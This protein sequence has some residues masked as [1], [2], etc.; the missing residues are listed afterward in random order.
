MTREIQTKS[1]RWVDV[2]NA[3]PRE[4]EALKTRFGFIPLH[5]KDFAAKGQR[6]KL[7]ET[8][9]YLFLVLLFPVYD[10]KTR[11][12]VP[13]EIDF[14]LGSDYLV[15]VH[16]GK[17][18]GLT[19]LYNLVEAGGSQR[20]RLLD[21]GSVGLLLRSL[22]RLL[23][24]CCPMLDHISLDLKTVEKKIFRGE[25]RRMVSEILISRRNITDFRRI[26][27][28]HKN[29][30]KKLITALRQRG[31][32]QKPNQHFAFEALIDD[33]KEIWEQLEG[34]RETVEAL[35]GTN[36]SLI[37]YQL[38]TIMKNF[39]T[40]SVMIFAMT[41]LATLFAIGVHGTPLV[42]LRH[43]FWYIVGLELILA[44]SLYYTFKHKRWL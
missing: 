38:S 37:S 2:I 34:H 13:S 39:T 44:G 16:D 20:N 24:A 18:L 10:R 26:M 1:V 33:T 31:R 40:L 21:G 43:G 29:T 4:L 22:E 42:G 8:P 14:A 25:E 9:S 27:Q 7:D 11:E 17:L 23:A 5:L 15:T 35:H 12:I 28:A 41:L 3:T 19:E 32:I 30:L 6:P 36:E